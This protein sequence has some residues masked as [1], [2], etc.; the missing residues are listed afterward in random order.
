[1]AWLLQELCSGL[2]SVLLGHDVCQAPW[3]MLSFPLAVCSVMKFQQKKRTTRENWYAGGKGLG[4]QLCLNKW[5][6]AIWVA[7]RFLKRFQAALNTI[8]NCHWGRQIYFSF[9]LRYCRCYSVFC[10]GKKMF[11][12]ATGRF[13]SVRRREQ[14]S[15]EVI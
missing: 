6:Q 10:G 4:P 8:N 14:S 7:F 3:R 12:E 15:K 5:Q 1:M 9:L 13:P 11:L 2:H